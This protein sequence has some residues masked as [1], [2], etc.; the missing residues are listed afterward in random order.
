MNCRA[1]TVRALA[2]AIPGAR[3][4]GSAES[5]VTGVVYESRLVGPGDLFAALRGADFDGHQFVQNAE[6]RGAAALLVESPMPT[7]LPQIQ[8]AD[9][10]AAYKDQILNREARPPRTINDRIPKELESICL[11]CLSKA[12]SE[13]YTTADDLARDLRR[14]KAQ[15]STIRAYRGMFA[16]AACLAS[17]VLAILFWSL[18]QPRTTR[19]GPNQTE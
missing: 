16:V 15:R 13:R 14:W 5:V 11:K 8:V 1:S 17:P 2:G 4:L 6:E 18:S 19:P 9:T 10:R 7:A 3:I 12:I